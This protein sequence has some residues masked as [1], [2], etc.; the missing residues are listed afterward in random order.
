LWPVFH[1]L[2]RNIDYSEDYWS[3]YKK[4]NEIFA[5]VVASVASND[6]MIWIHDYHL[7]LLPRLIR[8]II[9][10]VRLGFFLHIPFPSSEIFRYR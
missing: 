1:Y 3:S 4:A 8:R 9:E 2:P 6:D 5:Q 10:P 7:I